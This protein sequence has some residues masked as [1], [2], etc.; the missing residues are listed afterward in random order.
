MVSQFPDPFIANVGVPDEW[1]G[2]VP[3]IA[4]TVSIIIAVLGMIGF[5]IRRNGS[6]QL[7]RGAAIVDSG[8]VERNA[9]AIERSAVALEKLADTQDKI[10][11]VM[12]QRDAAEARESELKDIRKQLAAL[13][14]TL[15]QK[16]D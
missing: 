3:V 4:V 9:L 15:Q 1:A 7:F 2:L 11:A 14:N 13:Q 5:P 12:R 10:L 16:G 8:A 6:S